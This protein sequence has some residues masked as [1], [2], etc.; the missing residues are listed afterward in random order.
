M[1][2]PTRPPPHKHP[3]N[4]WLGVQITRRLNTKFSSFSFYSLS[5]SLSVRSK[6]FLQHLILEETHVNVKATEICSSLAA[7]V[8]SFKSLR[9]SFCTLCVSLLVIFH[10]NLWSS[11]NKVW[12]KNKFIHNSFQAQYFLR[13]EIIKHMMLIQI[14]HQHL[15]SFLHYVPRTVH[16][17]LSTT[18]SHV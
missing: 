5:L 11:E 18:R 1:P 13:N 14:S 7:F 15:I 6:C 9:C 16:I 2:R 4:S 17:Q 3:I 12:C 10:S 8:I